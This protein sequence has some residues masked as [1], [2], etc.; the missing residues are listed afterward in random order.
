MNKSPISRA[1]RF[2]AACCVLTNLIF[3]F[4]IFISTLSLINIY[5]NSLYIFFALTLFSWILPLIVWLIYK[6]RH[7]FID[8]SAREALNFTMSCCLYLLLMVSIWLGSCF[9]KSIPAILEGILIVSV[10]IAPA[11]FVIHSYTIIFGIVQA[12]SGN[13]YKYPLTIHFFI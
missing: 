10:P 5:I 9:A 8:N 13:V 1:I 11:I 4:S 12:A 2:R 6:K 3:P 7:P